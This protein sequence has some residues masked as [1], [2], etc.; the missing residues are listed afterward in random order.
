MPHG[1]PVYEPASQQVLSNYDYVGRDRLLAEIQHKTKLLIAA[2]QRTRI[3]QEEISLLKLDLGELKEAVAYKSH[4]LQEKD[5]TIQALQAELEV[6][7]ASWTATLQEDVRKFL[8][9]EVE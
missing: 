4:R 9:P 1:I 6:W 2:Q 3:L 5:A 7:R 8:E